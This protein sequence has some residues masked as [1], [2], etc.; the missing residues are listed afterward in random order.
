LKEDWNYTNLW[1][2]L[3]VIAAVTAGVIAVK[4]I[5]ADHSP[6]FYYVEHSAATG[7]TLPCVMAYRE[8]Y[9]NGVVYCSDDVNK[10]ISVMNQMNASIVKK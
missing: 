10:A 6:K 8:W 5:L 1:F 7:T 2:C 4:A 3:V 9:T